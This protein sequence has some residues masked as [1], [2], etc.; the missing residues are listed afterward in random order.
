MA[1]FSMLTGDSLAS[2]GPIRQSY[3]PPLKGGLIAEE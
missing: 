3:D 1:T 2:D